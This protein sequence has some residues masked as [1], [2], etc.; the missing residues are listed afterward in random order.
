PPPDA[1]ALQ[2]AVADDPSLAPTDPLRIAALLGQANV[3]A[4]KGD[5]AGAQKAFERTGLTGEQ[6]AQLGLSPARRSTG[7]QTSGYPTA[8]RALGFE[9]WVM[10]EADVRPDGRTAAQRATISYPPFVFDDAAVG[11][12]KIVRYSSSFRPEGAL[13]CEGV[14]MPIIFSIEQ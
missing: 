5:L 8:A 14:R 3:L 12:A 7:S 6:C 13:A 1:A 11:V 4:A 9:G 10:A 2:A